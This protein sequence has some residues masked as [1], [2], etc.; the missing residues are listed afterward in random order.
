MM[1]YTLRVKIVGDTIPVAV[2][3]DERVGNIVNRLPELYLSGSTGKPKILYDGVEL[4]EDESWR[5]CEVPDG[6][7]V[8]IE[9]TYQLVVASVTKHTPADGFAKDAA[10]IDKSFGRGAF[11]VGGVR[12]VRKK[13]WLVTLPVLRKTPFVGIGKA[14]SAMKQHRAKIARQGKAFSWTERP[15]CSARAQAPTT[16]ELT[17]WCHFCKTPNAKYASAGPC[18][19]GTCR[20]QALRSSRTAPI[21]RSKPNR[22]RPVSPPPLRPVSPPPKPTEWKKEMSTKCGKPY[23]F[24]IKTGESLWLDDYQSK[25]GSS[26]SDSE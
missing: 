15:T 11:A 5:G 21:S 20:E 23:M 2:D 17:K 7:A 19:G 6:G 14:K 22:K 24:N 18:I 25:Y 4:N 3:S 8:L 26:S 10:Y 12:A 13:K 16:R 9:Y 1:A